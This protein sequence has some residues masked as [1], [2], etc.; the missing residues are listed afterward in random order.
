MNEFI[1]GQGTE[2]MK[3]DWWVSSS[4]DTTVYMTGISFDA[5]MKMQVKY[6][7]SLSSRAE[8]PFKNWLKCSNQISWGFWLLICRYIS[9]IYQEID[10][11]TLI[12]T[13]LW[14][15]SWTLVKFLKLISQPF[16]G[17]LSREAIIK[18]KE[19]NG[20]CCNDAAVDFVCYNLEFLHYDVST[21]NAVLVWL[22]VFLYSTFRNA[23]V[24]LSRSLIWNSVINFF[25]VKGE[26]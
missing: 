11:R 20:C 12:Q 6:S 24:F 15:W 17:W 25:V 23:I 16:F 7:I 21:R 10:H 19:W 5:V 14:Q 8:K 2:L 3:F 13:G 22:L 1:E 26:G 4:L 9:G 18:N